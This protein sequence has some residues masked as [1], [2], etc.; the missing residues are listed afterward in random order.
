MPRVIPCG[1]REGAFD[2]FKT[3]MQRA[4]EDCMPMLLVDSEEPVTVTST[5]AHLKQRKGDEWDKPDNATDAH[6]HLMVQCME[7]WFLADLDTLK[8]YYGKDFKEGA[9]PIV[10]QGASIE[11]VAKKKI[12]DGFKKATKPTK[13]KGVYSK[14]KHSFD[15]LGM[16]D[17]SNIV[18]KSKFAR[19]LIDELKA[20]LR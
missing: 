7:A 16:I 9:L 5:W 12:E 13:S 11:N 17:P 6:V 1:G 14:G 18:Q 10:S 3:A 19:R 4:S 2:S 15:I 20:R 8:K